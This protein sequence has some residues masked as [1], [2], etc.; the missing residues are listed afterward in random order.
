MSATVK[1]NLF[2]TTPYSTVDLFNKSLFPV[3]TNQPAHLPKTRAQWCA[4]H[5]TVP[6][7][8][9]QMS[10][11]THPPPS[12]E[13]SSICVGHNICSVVWQHNIMHKAI[14]RGAAA[15]LCSGHYCLCL[16]SSKPPTVS[17]QVRAMFWSEAPV[18]CRLLVCEHGNK[19]QTF[20]FTW[21]TVFRLH[22]GWLVHFKLP[23][24]S[25]N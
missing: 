2:I 23:N 18:R 8:P 3:S 25:I 6:I 22:M 16:L 9:S 1:G 13:I 5:F 10:Q 17:A 19:G 7:I 20:T 11:Q 15:T 14:H 4:K 21:C 12:Q 24:Q